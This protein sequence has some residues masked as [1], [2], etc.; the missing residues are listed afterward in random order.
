MQVNDLLDRLDGVRP[1][2]QGKYSSSC[3]AHQDRNPS[4]SVREGDRGILVKC[5]AGCSLADICNALVILPRQLFY[6]DG[7]P[8]DRGTIRRRQEGKKNRYDWRGHA[9]ELQLESDTKFL[10]AD[11]FL[12][13]AKGL[14][15]SA[16]TEE[17]LEMAWGP[18]GRATDSADLLALGNFCTS[19][20]IFSPFFF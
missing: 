19:E 2:G 6:D 16:W 9:T 5:W 11:H 17:D 4:L 12:R 10:Q 3:P 18:I 7:A 8:M 14:D 1:R 20:F 15:I 13:L